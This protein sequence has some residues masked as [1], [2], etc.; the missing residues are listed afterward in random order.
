MWKRLWSPQQP[1]YSR[2]WTKLTHLVLVAALIGVAIAGH[3]IRA[4]G[5]A[6]ASEQPQTTVVLPK[7]SVRF[8]IYP[9]GIHPATAKVRKGVV[10]IAIEDLA[11]TNGGVVVD[12]LTEGEPT[13][14]GNVRRAQR[15]WRG[16][17]SIELSPG[18]YRLRVPGRQTN[19]AQLTVEP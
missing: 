17:L 5:G 14:V 6:E 4:W 11:G 18:I 9:E 16:R 15:H 10:S 2:L 12:R 13:V 7:Q 1:G 8:T 19:E 3:V